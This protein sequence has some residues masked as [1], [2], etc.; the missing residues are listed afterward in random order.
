MPGRNA[1]YFLMCLH[2]EYVYLQ[3]IVNGM[4]GTAGQH[5]VK[6]VA[7]ALE[8]APEPKL[9]LLMGDQNALVIQM[10]TNHV[11]QMI[12]Q[13]CNILLTLMHGSSFYS[14]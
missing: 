10:K 11:A 12:V 1:F 4:N 14:Y 7:L 13:V 2:I 8:A 3:L 6:H 5:V 9:M